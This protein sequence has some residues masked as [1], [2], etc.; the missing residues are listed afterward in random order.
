MDLGYV[1][2]RKTRWIIGKQLMGLSFCNCVENGSNGRVTVANDCRHARLIQGLT[3]YV[4]L[5]D[6]LKYNKQRYSRPQ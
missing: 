3:R 6:R 2:N 1:F 5:D 4:L